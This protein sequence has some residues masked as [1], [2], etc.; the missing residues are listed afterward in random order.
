M[1]DLA[2]IKFSEGVVEAW[3]E[4]EIEKGDKGAPQA[5]IVLKPPVGHRTYDV[6]GYS[7]SARERYFHSP[8]QN[9]AKLKTWRRWNNMCAIAEKSWVMILLRSTAG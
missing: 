3:L 6:Q 9:Y 1:A 4:Q 8:I 2:A 7:Y 5:A